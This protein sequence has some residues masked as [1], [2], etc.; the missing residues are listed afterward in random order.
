MIQ[1]SQKKQRKREYRPLFPID[2]SINGKTVTFHSPG[3]SPD[4]KR[5]Y[6]FGYSKGHSDLLIKVIR[7]AATEVEPGKCDFGDFLPIAW[8]Y[9]KELK[10][11]LGFKGKKLEKMVSFAERIAWAWY[12]PETG[13]SKYHKEDK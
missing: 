2:V 11:A 9:C 7:F 10:D 3:E 1:I 6:L 5:F 13:K 4:M 12:D 8:C